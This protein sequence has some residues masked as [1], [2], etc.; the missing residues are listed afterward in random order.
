M[1]ASP[2]WRRSTSQHLHL[3]IDTRND[4][5]HQV[6]TVERA[7]EHCRVVQTQLLGD[8]LAHARGGRRGVRV[9]AGLREA[10]LELG[11]L[12]VFRPEVVTPV[13]DA[14]GFIDGECAHLQPL[15]ELQEAR[16][17][18]ALRRDEYQAIAAGRDLRLG[19][20]DGIERHAAI[21]GS[22]RIARF[23][24]AHRPDPSST[25]S[26]ARRRCRSAA[27]TPQGPDSKATCRRRSA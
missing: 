8:V 7:D 10:G 26:A 9:H 22:R 19:L 17:Q 15:D 21:K 3:R 1:A 11:E 4:A 18:Q 23:T 5:I 25:R 14:M 16:R 12:A 6:G 13:A 20:T 27:P 2:G 24:R